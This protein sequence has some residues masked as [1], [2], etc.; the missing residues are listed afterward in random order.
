MRGLTVNFHTQ[1]RTCESS[2]CT[3]WLNANYRTRSTGR[4]PGERGEV[5]GV[6]LRAEEGGVGQNGR[7]SRV[8]PLGRVPLLI[9]CSP[10]ME[11]IG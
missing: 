3:R 11:V 2:T 10:T 1:T 7:G 4:E 9:A 6:Q 5:L 8:D